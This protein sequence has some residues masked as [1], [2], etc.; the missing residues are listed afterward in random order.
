[1]QT[2]T[3][4]VS[5]DQASWSMDDLPDETVDNMMVNM[6]VSVR[7]KKN[8]TTGINTTTKEDDKRHGLLDKTTQ[9]MIDYSSIFDV[10][11]IR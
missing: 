8:E 6:T 3:P 7:Y 5:S 4:A 9:L 10:K 1:M 2:S 11:S